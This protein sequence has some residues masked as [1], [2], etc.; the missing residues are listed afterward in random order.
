MQVESP[1]LSLAE[2]QRQL[3]QG[4]C[5]YCGAKGHVIMT[6]PIR[7]PR[8]VVSFVHNVSSH[9]SPLTYIVC[10]TASDVSISVHA[11]INSG[12]AGSFIPEDLCHHLKHKK[13]SKYVHYKVHS[14]TGKP[15]SQE[16][17]CFSAGPL[18]LRV[19]LL[20]MEDIEFLVLEKSVLD[21]R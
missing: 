19:G 18:Y 8:P 12:S 6:C 9:S 14:T 5:L 2:Q 1:C 4:L 11:L 15:L 21:H 16:Q 3:A 10:L 20:H 7:P 13:R 17:M